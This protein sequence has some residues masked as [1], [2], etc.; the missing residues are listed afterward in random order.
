MRDTIAAGVV[1]VLLAVMVLGVVLNDQ[2]LIAAPLVL[3]VGI[4]LVRSELD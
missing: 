3:G 2:L 1:T 4:A